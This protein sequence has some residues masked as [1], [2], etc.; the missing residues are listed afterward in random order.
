MRG[1]AYSP[2]DA[3]HVLVVHVSSWLHAPLWQAIDA[4]Q[5]FVSMHVSQAV[6]AG[7]EPHTCV[8]VVGVVTPPPLLLPQ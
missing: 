5:R 6:V 3:E 7:V 4:V 2:H 8:E 1:A